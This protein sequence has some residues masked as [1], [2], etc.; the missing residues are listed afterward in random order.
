MPAPPTIRRI[1]RDDW[2]AV[3]RLIHAST[4]AWYRANRGF[5]IFTGDADSCEW[6]P[7]VYDRLDGDAC[8]VAEDEGGELIGSCFFHP[9]PTHVGLGIMN[10]APAAFGTGVARRLLRHV[11]AEADGRPV[12]LVSSAMNLDSF[13]LYTNAGF[14]PRQLYQ[15]MQFES[16]EALPGERDSTRRATADDLDAIAALELEISGIDRRSDWQHFIANVDGIWH[17]LVCD[18]GRRGIVGVLGSVRHPSSHMIGPGVARDDHIAATLLSNQLAYHADV[19]PDSQ[20]VFLLPS[21]RATLVRY[22]Y[23]WGA[24]NLETHVHN[25]LGD[26]QPFAGVNFPTFMP[27][28]G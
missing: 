17:T 19:H 28:S 4:N 3:A 22:A 15:D 23:V 2:P 1:T 5:D 13:S 11:I 18:H 25:V 16:V 14:V 10:V 9:R 8:L 24:R 7:R 21:D 27:E 12:R 20:P 26:W 6:F